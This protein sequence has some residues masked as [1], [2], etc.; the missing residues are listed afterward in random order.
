MYLLQNSSFEVLKHFTQSQS[1]TVLEY[2]S[3]RVSEIEMSGDIC[4]E[5]AGVPVTG[6]WHF[7]NCSCLRKE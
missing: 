2:V 7:S 5:T 6:V 3:S 4:D 1:K